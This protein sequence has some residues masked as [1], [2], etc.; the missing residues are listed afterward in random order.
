MAT[1]EDRKAAIEG[2][3]KTL[4][5]EKTKL[6]DQGRSI[7]QALNAINAKQL[8]LQGAFREIEALLTTPTDA[9]PSA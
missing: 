5:Q 9:P 1:L 2:E 4:E 8:Q 7:Q 6:V 3:F